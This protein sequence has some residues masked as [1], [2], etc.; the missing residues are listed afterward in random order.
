MMVL[1]F[2]NPILNNESFMSQFTTQS[3][4]PQKTQ[5][6]QDTPEQSEN[7]KFRDPKAVRI[8]RALISV[9][10]KHG[11]VDLAKT[12]RN[13]DIEILSTGGT[14]QALRAEDIEVIELAEFTGFPE[15]LEGRVK[16]LN[17]KVHGGL[18][19]RRE[20]QDHIDQMKENDIQDIDLLVVNL[21][22][23]RETV[24]GGADFQT[25]IENIDIGGPA[26]IRSAAKNHEF[27]TVVTNPSD[28]RM[29]IDNLEK[30]DGATSISLRR[31]LS[32]D[33]FAHT[34][35]YDGAVATWFS[36]QIEEEAFPRHISFSGE[37]VQS[38]R[39]GE[40]PHQNAAVY[41]DGSLRPGVV[42]ASQLQGKELSYNNLND[43]DAA[44][45]LVA[46]FA[47]PA[48]AIIKHANPCG[49]AVGS[50][51]LNA[52]Q[53]AFA[54]DPISAF[55]GIIAVN[56]PLKAEAAEEI[57][58]TFCEVVIAP[59]IEPGAIDILKTKDKIRVLTTGAMPKPEDHMWQVKTVSGGM[60][61]QNADTKLLDEESLKIVTDRSPT[62][63]EK[64]DLIFAFKVCKHV[65][66][67]AIVFAKGQQTLGI[68][69]GQM[70]RID[71]VRIAVN[72]SRD[73]ARQ[74]GKA[75]ENILKGSVM[76][77]DA[78]FPFPDAMLA[79]ADAGATAVIHPGGSIKDDLVVE[80]ADERGL[81]MV[82]TSQRHF[83]H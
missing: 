44:F 32:A 83:R 54:C 82:L 60:L 72:K 67:N 33:A 55:G 35:S 15:I 6:N 77:S 18:L 39:Y 41:T 65:K 14:A 34:A 61:V 59:S 63:L 73:I 30:H 58:K 26:M 40:N 51:L 20:S 36:G 46:E 66:S 2:D 43:T 37:R 78:F 1:P 7:N 70:S 56:K 21:Y 16:T 71:S 45:Q 69:A 27:V 48:V 19:G 3:H 50:S 4:S 13:Y 12:L 9:S 28:Y 42:T 10:D 53:K 81:A 29:L 5:D 38:L 17:P 64:E 57:V 62:N 11:L 47:D 8:K 75:E 79:G 52:Y 74:D 25:C 49:V 24:D 22:P 76:A 68:G 23:F 80:A 31:K